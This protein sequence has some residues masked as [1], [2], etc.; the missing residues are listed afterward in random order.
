MIMNAS[1]RQVCALVPIKQRERCKTRLAAALTPDARLALV[2]S[3]LRAVLAAACGTSTVSEIVLLSPERD[4]VPTEIPV[5]ADAGDSLNAALARAHE[6]MWQTGRRELVILPADLPGVTAQEIDA[7]VSAGRGDGFALA[8]DM[9][10]TGTNALFL[11]SSPPFG[12][13]FGANSCQRHLRQAQRLGLAPRLV[14]LPGLAFDVDTPADLAQWQR[15][16]ATAAPPTAAD[17]ARRHQHPASP[18]TWP[19]PLRA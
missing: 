3:M 2:R 19:A 18:P 6:A 17:H 13:Q 15:I 4:A 12:F 14:R 9:A 16:A 11:A 7:L 8:P 5:L 1:A 10:G